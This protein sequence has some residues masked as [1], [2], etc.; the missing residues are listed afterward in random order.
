M[1]VCVMGP[2][3]GNSKGMRFKR[4]IYN[5]VFGFFTQIVTIALSLIVPRLILKSYGSEVNGLL[6]TINNIYTYLALVEA[7]IGT[8]ALQALYKPVVQEDYNAINGILYTTKCYYRRCVMLYL[9]GVLS[10]SV[11]LPFVFSSTISKLTIAMLV[12]LQG[13]SNLINFYLL[14]GITVL[15]SAEGKGYVQNTI[16]LVVSIAIN[17][18]KIVLMN[19][20]VDIIILQLSYFTINLF[21]V[22]IYLIYF[23]RNY[24][25]L[26]RKKK[27]VDYK[28]KQRGSFLIHNVVSVIF[29]N[30]DVILLSVFCGLKVSSIYAIYNMVFV[31]LMQLINSIFNGVKFTLGQVYSE[32]KERYMELHDTYKSYYCAFVFA[33]TSVCYVLLLPFIRLYTAG[34]SDI[35]YLDKRLPLLFC[36]INLLSSC[37]STESNLISLAFKAKQTVSRTILEAVINLGISIVLVSKIGIYGCL[38]GTIVA[39]FYR[40]NDMIIYANTKILNRVPRQA[41]ITVIT[42]FGLFGLVV[43]VSNKIDFRIDNYFVFMCYGA[44]LTIMFMT[45]YILANSLVNMKGCIYGMDLLK[46]KWKRRK[47]RI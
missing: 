32:S 7:G 23:R 25:W 22:V 9:V 47:N 26:D 44:I 43:L 3:G 12:I 46:S 31:A 10:V 36:L 11:I 17:I 8:S 38:I 39:L 42:N 1:T 20:G 41:Y 21:S 2:F 13:A 16:A 30:T 29:N 24:K 33:A 19:F 45:I 28:L 15:L 37:R 4:V 34:I 6:S 27:G 40:T 5:I 35:D 18:S 14:A